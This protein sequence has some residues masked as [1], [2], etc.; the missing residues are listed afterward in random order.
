MQALF[1]LGSR[2]GGRN[3][4]FFR[5]VSSANGEIFHDRNPSGVNT[6]KSQSAGE[7]ALAD[8]VGKKGLRA[9]AL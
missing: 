9:V 4:K 1:L 8:C 7:L 6:P 3:Y 2:S 5:H